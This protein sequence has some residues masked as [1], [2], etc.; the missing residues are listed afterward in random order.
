MD[1]EQQRL[2]ETSGGAD[3]I[4]KTDV[5]RPNEYMGP[6]RSTIAE[7]NR[8]KKLLIIGIAVLIFIVALTVTLVLVLRKK[9]EPVTPPVD[10]TVHF[11]PYE[12]LESKPE[13]MYYKIGRNT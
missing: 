7:T 11:N 5:D 2:V 8:K 3:Q 6:G 4:N 10:P 9:D 12:V 1:S 13:E